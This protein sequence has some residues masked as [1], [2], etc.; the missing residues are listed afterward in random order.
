MHNKIPYEDLLSG[1]YI[2]VSRI[3]HIRSPKIKDMWPTSGIGWLQYNLYIYMMRSDAAMLAALSKDEIEYDDV[4]DV[5]TSCEVVRTLFVK[6]LSFFMLES[7]IYDESHQAFLTFVESDNESDDPSQKLSLV[8]IINSE[9]ID[10]LRASVL[11]ANYISPTKAN[12]DIEFASEKAREMWERAQKYNAQQAPKAEDPAMSLGNIV[13]KLC[14]I[15]PSYNL[16]N[17]FDLTVFQLYDAFFQSCYMRSIEFSESIVANHGSKE[18]K[19]TN[20]LNPVEN[21]T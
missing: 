9:N 11:L 1:D 13:S 6:A 10:S 17:V 2:P 18:F 5:I 20:W 4:Y 14:T 16:L 7:V 3:G 15:H 21:Y 19:Y 8:G 12:V